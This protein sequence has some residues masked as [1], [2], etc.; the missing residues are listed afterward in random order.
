[1]SPERD[2]KMRR[3]TM[4]KR[5]AS[6]KLVTAA[7]TEGPLSFLTVEPKVSGYLYKNNRRGKWQVRTGARPPVRQHSPNAYL[8]PRVGVLPHAPPPPA[9]QK[10]W[11]EIRGPFLMYW[12]TKPKTKAGQACKA[13]D[14]AIDIRRTSPTVKVVGR[15]GPC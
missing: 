5:P 6:S 9:L 4:H 13:P 10:R 8:P 14:A 15:Q 1:M 7:D 3:K 12:P 11:C 2:E